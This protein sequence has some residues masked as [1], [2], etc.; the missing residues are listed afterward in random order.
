MRALF[1]LLICLCC[2]SCAGGGGFDRLR[3]DRAP[4]PELP[5]TAAASPA[6]P[7]P[8]SAGQGGD[9][10]SRYEQAHAVAEQTSQLLGGWSGADVHLA[11]ARAALSAGD[12]GAAL[13]ASDEALA[14]T[15]QAISDY[16]ATRANEEL[17][18]SYSF[19]GLDDGQ[20]LQLRAAEEILVTGNSRLAY[21][22]LRTL[23]QQLEK[24]LKTYTVKSGDNL[25]VIAGRPEVYAN[26]LLWPLVWQAN[27]QI[28][29]NPDRLRRGQVLKVRPHPS[30][31]EVAEAVRVAR[32]GK[33]ELPGVKPDIGEIQEVEP[34]P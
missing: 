33:K 24:R 26:S 7:T 17:A 25:W 4:A 19:S 14:A 13:A 8:A 5:S 18:R 34:G 6:P 32:R 3:R 12:R 9:A 10:S 28:I 31:N 15:D 27:A 21:G 20:V 30:A 16:Y 1:S 2:A 29:P 23:N 11:S 22:R